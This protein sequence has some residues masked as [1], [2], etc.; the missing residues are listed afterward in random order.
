MT[1]RDYYESLKLIGEFLIENKSKTE[2]VL[3]SFYE[4]D[5]F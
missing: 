4:Q 3:N 2:Y 1:N 5:V